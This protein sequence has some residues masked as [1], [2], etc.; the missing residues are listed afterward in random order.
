MV[1]SSRERWEAL[2]SRLGHV[3][4]WKDEPWSWN[5]INKFKIYWLFE[6]TPNLK[7]AIKIESLKLENW[8]FISRFSQF[9]GL[10]YKPLKC[11]MRLLVDVLT[12]EDIA[13]QSGQPK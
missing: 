13:A 6:E 1:M 8:S 7:K 3:W 4:P 9:S 10:E 5:Q 2:S 11:N 12:T